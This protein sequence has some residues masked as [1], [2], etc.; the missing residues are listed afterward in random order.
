MAELGQNYGLYKR[1]L[2]ELGQ[3]YGLCQPNQL[4]Q[5]KML[6]TLILHIFTHSKKVIQTLC[7]VT[8][9]HLNIHYNKLFKQV[10]QTLIMSSYTKQLSKHLLC[11]VTQICYLNIHNAKLLKEVMVC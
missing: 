4:S 5:H 9:R 7:H 6:M 10:I 11:Q 8:Q 3:N 1:F 2:V